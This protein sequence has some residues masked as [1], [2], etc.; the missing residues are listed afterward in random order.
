MQ[1]RNVIGSTTAVAVAPFVDFIEA[2]TPFVIIAIVLIITDSRFGI[3]AAE[4]RGETIRT[5][6]MWRR[7]IN[8]LVDYICW[9]LLAGVFSNTYSSIL[10]V[11]MMTALVMLVVYCIELISIFN[12]Y[13]EYKGLNFRISFSKVA[14]SAWKRFTKSGDDIF[15]E[16]RDA[17][18][19]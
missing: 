12:N 15:N 16:K 5:S 6:R 9:V 4:K 1:E 17:E 2:L 3:E 8:K 10:G 19:E 11:P 13:F 7:A 18:R 14:R